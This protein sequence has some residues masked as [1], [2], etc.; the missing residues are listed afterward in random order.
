MTASNNLH[1]VILAA[2]QG[3]RMKSRKPKV[4]QELAGQ[5]LLAHVLTAAEALAPAVVHVVYG[6]G[7]AD[8][9][10][11]FAE[12]SVNWVEQ[13]EQ[14]GT[15]HALAQAIPD[16][17]DG[18]QVVVLYGDVPLIAAATLRLLVKASANSLALLTVR[19]AEPTG[20]GRIVRC[21]QGR[22]LQI[23]EQ[24]DANPEQL[25]IDEVNTGFIAAEA[26]KLR[27]WLATLRSDNAQGE[28]YLTD[29]IARSVAEGYPVTVVEAA[30]V[31][32]ILG[33]NDRAQLATLERIYQ[34]RRAL[35]HMQ[36]GL[37]LADPGRLDIRGVLEHGM[38]CY[39]DINC[40]I[41]GRVTLADNVHVGPNCVLRNVAIGAGSRIQAY[42]HLDGAQLGK[43]T[44]VG[45]F[46]RLRE[47]TELGD[48]T[49]VGNF[50][51][52]KKAKVGNRSKINHLSYVGDAQLGQDVNVG[53]GTI[54]CNYDGANKHQTVIGD[55][56]FVG[57]NSALVAPVNVGSDA[58]IGAGSTI[59]RDAPSGALTVSRARQRS[60]SGWKRPTKSAKS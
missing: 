35:N 50:V 58:T 24:K 20:Y 55:R 1:V 56:A 44:Q 37:M 15:G 51:E 6:H 26:S 19:L 57:S 29:C 32:E 7:G 14:H 3:T 45:P 40:V 46:A 36:Q 8:V 23:V 47:G 34:Q 4:L 28:Y 38:D 54:T 53:A 31:D 39:I 49:K 48:D 52:T 43:R 30:D 11:A 16:I 33:V 21:D 27:A 59:G 41:E 5:P 18:A 13:A 25:R 9:R 22:V 12:A 10:A 42:S 17:P 60:V 2:G